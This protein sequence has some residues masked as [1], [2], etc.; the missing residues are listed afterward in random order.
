MGRRSEELRKRDR[1]ILAW[2]LAAAALV[3][4][5]VFALA[6]SIRVEPLGGSDV[7]LDTT[8]VAGG[9]NAS[10]RV[11]FGAPTVVIADRAA[12]TAPPERVLSAEREVRLPDDCFGLASEAR[13]PIGSRVAL[14]I[15]ASGRVDV[16][17]LVA[18]S[19]DRCADQVLK[20][21]A[22]D[23]WYHWLPNERFE[24]PVN[25]EQPVT[26]IAAALVGL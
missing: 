1:R 9:A 4:V 8:G 21:V 15:R 10:V 7:E 3:H 24:A 25:V 26:L 12:W 16:L 14:R 22:A 5:A 11:F 19:G 13:T 6:P 23:L 17:G 2:S 18:S 20:D